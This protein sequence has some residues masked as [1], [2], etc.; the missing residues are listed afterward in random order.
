MENKGVDNIEKIICLHR[1]MQR[2]YWN[3]VENS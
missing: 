3:V 1:Y 2:L